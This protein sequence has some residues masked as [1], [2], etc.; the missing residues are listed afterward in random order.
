MSGR[1]QIKFDKQYRIGDKK[2]RSKH[3][4]TGYLFDCPSSKADTQ[5]TYYDVFDPRT[6]LESVITITLKDKVTGFTRTAHYNDKYGFYRLS[7]GTPGLH[8][9][10][11]KIEPILLEN[12]NR[13]MTGLDSLVLGSDRSVLTSCPIL[14]YNGFVRQEL[15]GSTVVDERF[16]EEV[17]YDKD[18][19]RLQERHLSLLSTPCKMMGKTVAVQKEKQ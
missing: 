17:W 6:P 5:F 14:G 18:R 9:Q 11:F 12:V 4:L 19:V 3:T 8:L 7:R 13:Y 1:I 16:F 10:N 15:M 2:K